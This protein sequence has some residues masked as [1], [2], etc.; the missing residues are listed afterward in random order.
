MGLAMHFAVIAFS[1][2]TDSDVGTAGGPAALLQAGLVEELWAQAHHVSGP[3]R[4]KRRG[5]FPHTLS[6]TKICIRAA[7]HPL[8]DNP[9]CAGA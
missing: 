3:H 1:Y 8:S 4:A 9:P 5:F 6:S 2:S 7:T